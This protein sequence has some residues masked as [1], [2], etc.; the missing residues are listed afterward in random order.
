M[1]QG[2]ILS[3]RFPLKPM[4][5][6]LYRDILMQRG[7]SQI[8]YRRAL[9]W[10]F[11]SKFCFTSISPAMEL[12]TTNNIF[13]SMKNKSRKY[14]GLPKQELNKFLQE[15]GQT[16][17]LLLSTIA[18]E[19]TWLQQDKE[20]L[21]LMRKLKQ[22]KNNRNLTRKVREPKMSSLRISR[23]TRLRMPKTSSFRSKNSSTKRRYWKEYRWFC[24]SL[25]TQ[26]I[27]VPFLEL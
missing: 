20:L 25:T 21:W 10:T 24:H 5:S 4:N 16:V 26:K 17:N 12:L 23:K 18:V 6:S 15:Q 3:L 13:C 19:K 7:K 9:P 11:N 22:S 2:T 27:I 14:S 8:S 1:K